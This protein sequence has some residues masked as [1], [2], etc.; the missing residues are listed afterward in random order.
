MLNIFVSSTYRDLSE[1][2]EALITRLNSSLNSIGME[3]FIPDGATSQIA[4]I[5]N[6][7]KANIVIFLLSSYYGTL[8]NECEI[9]DCIHKNECEIKEGD[10][11]SYTHCEYNNIINSEIPSLTYRIEENWNSLWEIREWE[12][13]DTKLLEEGRFQGIK[14]NIKHYFKIRKEATDFDMKIGSKLWRRISYESNEKE[15]ES[16]FDDL[17][18]KILEWY[19]ESKISFDNFHGRSDEL[20]ELSKIVNLGQKVEIFGVGGVGKTTLV[21]VFLLLQKLKGIRVLSIGTRQSYY[22]G[23][24][25]SNF[26]QRFTENQISVFGNKIG[27]DD[28]F[29]EIFPSE[30]NIS[31]ERKIKKLVKKIE[32]DKTLLFIDD[33]QFADEEVRRFISM[34]KTPVIVATKE[35]NSILE[36]VIKLKGIGDK[37]RDKHIMEVAKRFSIVLKDEDINKISELADGHPVSTELIIKNFERIDFKKIV[38]YKDGLNLTEKK[39]SEDFINRIIKSVINSEEEYKFLELVAQ[40][41]YELEKNIDLNALKKIE[42]NAEKY[43]FKFISYGL[44]EKKENGYYRFSYQH[45]KDILESDDKDINRKVHIYYLN[46]MLSGDARNEYTFEQLYHRMKAGEPK[47]SVLGSIISLPVEI[48]C[49]ESGYKR[50]LTFLEKLEEGFDSNQRALTYSSFANYLAQIKRFDYAEKYYEKALVLMG[51]I[52]Q[53][54]V[55]KSQTYFNLGILNEEL[56]EFNKSQKYYEKSV[57]TLEKFIGME[58]NQFFI[59]VTDIMKTYRI[60]LGSLYNIYCKNGNLSKLEEIEI[61]MKK[62][63]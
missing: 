46:K 44:I 49:K 63:K 56:N 39:H 50:I 38:K 23:S 45:I 42:K 12:E 15:L 47:I 14:E 26:I 29:E 35:S 16:I 27:I 20:I 3:F 2:R 11:I 53:F 40:I 8:M 60:F 52:P 34:L 62:L 58:E 48:V 43:F 36:N 1:K 32:E 25:Y 9:I 21:Q 7:K 55:N 51:D 22:S 5:S 19:K 54:L 30:I 33:F 18:K 57:E 17:Y 61:K 4:A 10:K 37:D 24:G 13:I 6:L 28:I 31:I 59:S 41:N